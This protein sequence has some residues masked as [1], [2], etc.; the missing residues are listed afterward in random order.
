MKK[1]SISLLMAILM[2]AGVFAG[3]SPSSESSTPD[4]KADSSK[5][6]ASTQDSSVDTENT[7]WLP[8]GDKPTLRQLGINQAVDYNT[9][10]V[11]AEIEALTGYHVEYDMLPAEG[12]TDK[13]NLIL[14]SSEDYDIIVFGGDMARVMEY[15]TQGALADINPY[16][17]YAPNLDAAL[18]DY[19]RESFTL[20]GGLYA[21]GMEQL[22]FDGKG[23]VRSALWMRQD[24]MDSLNLKAPGTTDELKSVLTAFKG[25]DNGTGTAAIPMTLPAS[26]VTIEGLIGAFGLPNTWNDVD[27]KLVYRGADPRMKDYLAYMKELYQEGLL[28]AEYPANQPAN[29][30]EKYASGIAGS[31]QF[32]FYDAPSVFTTMEETQP[33]QK[34]LY[35]SPVKGPAGDQAVGTDSGGF[36]RIAF[37]PS[38]SENLAHVINFMNIKLEQEN[39]VDLTVGKEGIHY[40]VDESGEKWPILPTFFDERGQAN[41]YSTGRYS[42]QYSELWQVRNRKDARQYDVWAQLNSEAFTQY[43]VNSEVNKAPAFPETSKNKQS[44][45]Q[46]M[47]DAQIKIIAGDETVDSYDAF[48][49]QWLAAGGQAMTDEY[50]TWY[51]EN[52]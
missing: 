2:L 30:M 52:K 27:G 17:Q 14:A 23:D 49:E 48:L 32:G 51:A 43:Q 19:E 22:S 29:S 21:V 47:L 5:S 10:P 15:A 34:T 11:A 35:L 50:N 18:N 33:K 8:E 39:F 13:L 41:N 28:D 26:S 4:S 20:D 44:L 25:Y 42:D 36:D 31:C 24:W 38:Y 12:A 40:S 3:C 46:M 7:E 6:S 9:Y 1:R 37:I 16:L 45:D